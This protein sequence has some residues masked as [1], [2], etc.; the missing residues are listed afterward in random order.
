MK[1]DSSKYGS[2]NLIGMKNLFINLLYPA[3]SFQIQLF[4]RPILHTVSKNLEAIK[5]ASKYEGV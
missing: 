3:F 4:L 1:L 5:I 2:L